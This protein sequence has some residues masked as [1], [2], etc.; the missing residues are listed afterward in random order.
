[1][2]IHVSPP[3][4]FG[5]RQRRVRCALGRGGLRADK[6]EGDGATPE[7]CFVLRQVMYRPDRLPQ[8]TTGL[9]VRPLRRDDGWCDDPAETAYNQLIGLPFPGHHEVL[10]RDDEIYDVVVTLG[11]NDD[12][13][14]AGR[15]S[16]IFLH[17]ARPDYATTEGCVAVALP[18][19]LALLRDCDRN[20]R[21]C[22]SPEPL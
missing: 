16:A 22:I 4:L 7:G 1:M 3:D 11:Y 9:P 2:D 21:L 6:R 5:W 10:W 15:G 18:D 20:T 19:L 12:P 14:T 8:P 13:V 17:V